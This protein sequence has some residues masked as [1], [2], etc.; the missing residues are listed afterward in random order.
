MLSN[1]FANPDSMW[2]LSSQPGLEPV[3]LYSSLN[4]WTTR[5]VPGQATF[6]VN[7]SKG[8]KFTELQDS[9]K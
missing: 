1:I 7:L 3:P 5:E 8:A 2:D 4:Y 9:Y 6:C